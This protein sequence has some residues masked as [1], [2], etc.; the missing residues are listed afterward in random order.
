MVNRQGGSPFFEM[1]HTANNA[2]KAYWLSFVI[3]RYAR[4]KN[5]TSDLVFPALRKF[6]VLD[7]LD[8]HYE[9][10][11]LENIVYVMEDMDNILTRN[12]G[13]LE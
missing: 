3:S 9:T 5:L 10:E 7:F 13:S 6:G 11:H 8:K 12:G 4:A 2:S 1:Q